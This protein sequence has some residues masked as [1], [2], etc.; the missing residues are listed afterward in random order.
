MNVAAPAVPAEELYKTLDKW[1]YKKGL[2]AR[3]LGM[4]YFWLSRIVDGY[5]PRAGKN[6]KYQLSK[7]T[8]NGAMDRAIFESLIFG[9]V[10]SNNF[11]S[12]CSLDEATTINQ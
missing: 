8:F 7:L 11:E 12:V 1:I 9:C 10:G 2:T 5:L 3:L 6:V 4:G